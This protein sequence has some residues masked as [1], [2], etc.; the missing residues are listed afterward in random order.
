MKKTPLATVEVGDRD[1]LPEG[2][3]LVTTANLF[4]F[5]TSGSRGWA[6]Y[7]AQD[8][9]LFL[10]IANL[11]HDTITID[12]SEK[13]YVRP[14]SSAEG[15]RTRV[16]IRDLLIS[17][18]ADVGMIGLIKNDLG[19]A[20]INQHIAL[21]RPAEGLDNEYLAWYITSTSAQKQLE[22]L[23]RGA[24]KVGLGL[25]DINSIHVPLAPIVE[26]HRIVAKIEELLG[27]VNAAR[28]RL[29]KVPKILKAFRQSVLAAA[30]SGRLTEADE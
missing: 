17:I 1:D 11:D 13:K 29:T 14:P 24:T 2:W 18:T 27:N 15:T 12:L 22:E 9:A 19:E 16:K 20:Y 23:Q 21:A 6:Q 7:Y 30:C 10:R 25:N 26:Q 3:A 28:D 8:G 5:V 4:S